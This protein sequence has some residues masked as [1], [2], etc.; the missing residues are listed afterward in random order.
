MT[1]VQRRGALRVAP[2]Y[3]TVPVVLVIAGVVPIDPLA[4]ERRYFFERRDVIGR[5]TASIKPGNSLSGIG[6]IV[7]IG[8][9]EEYGP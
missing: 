2:S 1:S 4:L 9:M 8:R 3:R 7:G 5:V 6:N